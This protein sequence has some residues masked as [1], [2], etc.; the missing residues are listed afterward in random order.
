MSHA[1]EDEE[2]TFAKHLVKTIKDA[3]AAALFNDDIVVRAS[4]GND[5]TPQAA[6]A[7]QAIVVLSR[8]YITQEH[9][10]NELGIILAKDIKIYPLYY[11]VT[12]DE[13]WEIIGK[14]DRQASYTI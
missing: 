6:E 4:S 2:E 8:S 7:N 14:Y 12:P 10:M 11:K 1:D 3:T 5:S 9:S 13:F